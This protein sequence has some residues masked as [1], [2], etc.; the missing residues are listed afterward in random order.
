MLAFV[1]IVR[2]AVDALVP[3]S[4]TETGL[5]LQATFSGASEHVKLT[6]WSKPAI[7]VMLMVD[8]AS[9]PLVTV[10][11][12]GERPRV[13]EGATAA[14][15]RFACVRVSQPPNQLAAVVSPEALNLFGTGV[16]YVSVAR[17]IVGSIASEL[18]RL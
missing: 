6:A 13:K 5:M 14:A 11:D 3:A 4:V 17:R 18:G 12:V 7:G 10:P 15:L 16:M 9:L 1:L 2:V 8:M